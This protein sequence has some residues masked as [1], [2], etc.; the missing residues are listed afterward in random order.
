MTRVDKSPEQLNAEALR[1]RPTADPDNSWSPMGLRPPVLDC[2][3]VAHTLTTGSDRYGGR[4]RQWCCYLAEARHEW[5]MASPKNLHVAL[6]PTQVEKVPGLGMVA[7]AGPLGGRPFSTE[8]N[9]YLDHPYEVIHRAMARYAAQ[10]ASRHAVWNDHVG[11]PKCRTLLHL[12]VAIGL[13]IEDAA[14]HLGWTPARAGR[15]LKIAL[16]DVWKWRVSAINDWS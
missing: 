6:T 16:E 15:L 5:R 14:I 2:H 12:T 3:R 10:C 13:P 8:F 1:R 4:H 9:A 7:D 11:Q